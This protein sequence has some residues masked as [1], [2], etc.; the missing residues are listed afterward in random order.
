MKF[1]YRLQGAG[2]AYAELSDRGRRVTVQASY[3]SDALGDLLS[4]LVELTEGG[5]TATCLWAEEPAVVR[6]TFTARYDGILCSMR[7]FPDEKAAATPPPHRY[8]TVIFTTTRPLPHLVAAVTD[9]VAGLRDRYCDDEYERRWQ[10][11]SFPSRRL[12]QLQEWL[13]RPVPS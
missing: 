8:G 12:D 6:W 2:W 1:R 5:R 10:A 11:A 4:A 13:R 3:L 9:E 7:R